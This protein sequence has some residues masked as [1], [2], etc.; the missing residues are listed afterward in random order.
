MFRKL[1]GAGKQFPQ[2]VKI[3]IDHPD[4]DVQPAQ[5]MERFTQRARRVLSM[6][7]EA[8]ENMGGSVIGTEHL[9]L[10]LLR[11]ENSVAGRVLREFGPKPEI[12]EQTILELAQPPTARAES[13]EL[14]PEVKKSLELA[15][16]EARRLGHH[17]IGT[18]HLLLGLMRQQDT[19]AAQVMQKL[20]FLPDRMRRRISEIWA[21]SA[22]NPPSA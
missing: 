4:S 2:D 10:A 5:K 14:A 6:A 9:L 12:T 18:E 20:H 8:A 21:E 15:V 3:Q 7:Q 19:V 13:V 22:Q 11:E 17:V 1:F 16:D